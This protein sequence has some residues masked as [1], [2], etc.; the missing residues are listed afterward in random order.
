ME[1]WRMSAP[2]PSASRLA[3]GPAGLHSVAG[4]MPRWT[5]SRRHDHERFDRSPPHREGRLIAATADVA[6]VV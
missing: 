4:S 1:D 6:V 2:P 5:A 3:V